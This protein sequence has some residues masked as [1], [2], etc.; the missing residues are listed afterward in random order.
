MRL[1]D[2]EVSET[3]LACSCGTGNC[4][5]GAE[6]DCKRR[7]GEGLAQRDEVEAH[8]W[9][10]SSMFAW[11]NSMMMT[12]TTI[13]II[14]F[15]FLTL[16]CQ[17]LCM[18]ACVCVRVC[19]FSVAAV[20]VFGF[21]STDDLKRGR[22]HAPPNLGTGANHFLFCFCCSSC[23]CR[24]CRLVS[25]ANKDLATMWT[26]CRIVR[27]VYYS[28]FSLPCPPQVLQPVRMSL[29]LLLFLCLCS[30]SSNSS[31]LKR[32][33]HEFQYNNANARKK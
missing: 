30:S 29:G 25:I 27:V 33:V 6:D 8:S 28:I 20:V 3:C 11:T 1:V 17:L 32:Y 31:I 18:C 15:Q 16:F 21:R 22:E 26:C 7:R 5:L 12:M 9:P 19:F 23:C 4:Q 14:I 10:A 2:R 13:V 24:C